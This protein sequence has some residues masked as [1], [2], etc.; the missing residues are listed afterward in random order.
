[1]VGKVKDQRWDGAVTDQTAR[2]PAA[3]SM[4]AACEHQPDLASSV[5]IVPLTC[6][7]IET[8]KSTLIVQRIGMTGRRPVAWPRTRPRSGDELAACAHI[9]R[10]RTR[11]GR[12]PGRPGFRARSMRG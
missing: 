4:G 12:R 8:F 7:S 6:D 2:R 10:Y 9:P 1:M 3:S 11:R 5:R